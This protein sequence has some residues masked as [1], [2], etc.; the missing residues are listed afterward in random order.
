WRF[1][2]ETPVIPALAATFYVELPTGDSKQ[3]LGSGLT[4]YWLN[5]IAQKSVTTK[6]RVTVNAGYLFAGNT[7]TGAVGIET[8]RGHV[9]AGGVSLLHDFTPRVTLGAE[10]IGGIATADELGRSQLQAMVGGQYAI[11]HG[12]AFTFG[13]LGGKYVA[14]PR[15]GGQ[16]G[17]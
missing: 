10:L 6:T 14:S 9:F 11:S 3:Q 2:N 12:V 4:D 16:I 7:S 1:H 8:T 13:V 15:I 17:V 5:L